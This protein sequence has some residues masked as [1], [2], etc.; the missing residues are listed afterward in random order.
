MNEDDTRNP[1]DLI[2]EQFVDR[3]RQGETPTIE[4]YRDAHP[5][6]AEQIEAL[7]PTLEMMERLKQDSGTS[8]SGGPV[9]GEV[10]FDRLGDFRLVREI[11]R[12]GMGIVYEAVQESLDRRVALK[13]LPPG[14]FLSPN[15]LERFQ[16]E[17]RAAARLHHTNIIP[18]YG[19]GE[20]HGTHYFAMQFI[21]GRPL[22]RVIR[23]A[24]SG[25]NRQL[26]VPEIGER[27]VHAA[28]AAVGAQV[29]EALAHAHAHR[30]LHR[31][32]KPANLILDE[33]GN[34][35]VADF[36]LAKHDEHDDITHGGG[37]LG[38]LRYTAPEQVDGD[39][40]EQSDVYALGM[41]LYEMI[42]LEPAFAERD[43]APLLKQIAEAEPL[44]LRRRD[45]RV[46]RDLET[47]VSRAIAK[48]PGRRY[49][50]AAA[51]EADLRRFLDGTPIHARRVGWAERLVRW[52]DRNRALATALG[53]TAASLAVA[54]GVGWMAYAET[55]RALQRESRN[56][57][58]SLQAFDEILETLLVEPRDSR[59]TADEPVR[60][61]RRGPRGPLAGEQ[62]ADE[63]RR[64]TQEGDVVASVL[65]FFEWFAENNPTHGE[66]RVKA[67]LAYR[68][69]SDLRRRTGAKEEAHAAI[70]RAASLLK[71]IPA[72]DEC[73]RAA[74]FE[75]ALVEVDRARL[76]DAEEARAKVH[77]DLALT[78]ADE[79]SRVAGL[80]EAEREALDGLRFR[81]LAERGR[82]RRVQERYD[83]A[84]AD[85]TRAIELGTRSSEAAEARFDRLVLD[86]V[87]LDLARV[88][89]IEDRPREAIAVLESL[90]D[91]KGRPFPRHPRELRNAHR[92]LAELYSKVGE[93]ERSA[94][95]RRLARGEP[96]L[97]RP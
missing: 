17:A 19:V 39:A 13:V 20:E 9:R 84:A 25:A 60:P 36:G 80:D 30:I 90:F 4:S 26:D 55:N 67:A 86:F 57:E 44:A 53:A 5:E 1:L 66:L 24:R 40:T 47:I 97:P 6:L 43:R 21:E 79:L 50:D 83:E 32:I 16:R 94:R 61:R 52:S 58:F 11:G 68:R 81:A 46:P 33:E 18:V 96:G 62:R 27:G 10:P 3:L 77:L 73:A 78:I 51:L 56:V 63:E 88:H 82:Q 92:L 76:D 89:S 2:A 29:A 49:R 72:E 23:D 69:V 22:D 87:A 12:G 59:S 42:A 41:T 75:L 45:R 48:S 34:V 28:I 8:Q 95:H 91:R 54:G 37:L 7:F 70:D 93:P 71:Q 65:E 64:V 35:W 15:K 74:R 31:D 38:T 14:V 85:L